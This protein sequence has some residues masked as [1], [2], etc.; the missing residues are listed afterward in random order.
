MRFLCCSTVYVYS[1]MT[2]EQVYV[3]LGTDVYKKHEYCIKAVCNILVSVAIID[4]LASLELPV[5]NVHLERI[6]TGFCAI[7]KK[8]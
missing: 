2:T 4:V 5:L 7:F 8:Q 6:T 1:E 3:Y